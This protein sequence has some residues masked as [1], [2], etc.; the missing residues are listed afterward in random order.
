ME[1]YTFQLL[2]RFKI[3]TYTFQLLKYF[4]METYFPITKML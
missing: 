1:T 2:K 3:E 4:K